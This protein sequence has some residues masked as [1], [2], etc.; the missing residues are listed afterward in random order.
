MI[1]SWSNV[2]SN[3]MITDIGLLIGSLTLYI[4]IHILLDIYILLI[5]F[6]EARLFIFKQFQFR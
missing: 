2:M 5:L 1:V 3:P 4:A 6:F